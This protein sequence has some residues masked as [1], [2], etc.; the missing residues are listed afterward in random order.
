MARKPVPPPFS[1]SDHL[2]ETGLLGLPEPLSKRT[3][4]MLLT[5][6]AMLVAARPILTSEQEGPIRGAVIMGRYLDD[7]EVQRLQSITH[8]SMTTR[9]NPTTG[10]RSRPWP[11]S[12]AFMSNH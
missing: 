4:I 11:R 1:F 2:S 8:L 12:R 6:A 7:Q 3:G 9:L 5:D 10:R